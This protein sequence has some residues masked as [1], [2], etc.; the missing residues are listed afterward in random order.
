MIFGAGISTSTAYTHRDYR[1]RQKAARA[2]VALLKLRR[3]ACT[4]YG[5]TMREYHQRLE[6]WCYLRRLVASILDDYNPKDHRDAVAAMMIEKKQNRVKHKAQLAEQR[7][8][9]KAKDDFDAFIGVPV[10]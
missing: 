3:D 1:K 7:I 9:K 4:R 2:R 5:I 10:D 8:E 6:E